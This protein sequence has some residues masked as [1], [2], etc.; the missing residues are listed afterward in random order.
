MKTEQEI[1]ER[2]SKFEDNRRIYITKAHQ[3]TNLEKYDYWFGR[4]GRTEEII[5]QLKWVLDN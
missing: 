4:V 2:L 5:Y 3:S 1:R